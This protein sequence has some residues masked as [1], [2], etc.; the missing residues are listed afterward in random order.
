M[1]SHMHAISPSLLNWNGLLKWVCN[2]WIRQTLLCYNSVHQCEG[3]SLE[4]PWSCRALWV[5]TLKTMSTSACMC[6]NKGYNVVGNGTTESC[7]EGAL[8]LHGCTS[9]WLQV[10][11]S[12]ACASNF[13]IVTNIQINTSHLSF[14]CQQIFQLVLPLILYVQKKKKANYVLMDQQGKQCFLTF[15]V[16]VLSVLEK[17]GLLQ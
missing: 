14:N 3:E 17:W 9:G 5:Q 2:P 13:A 8:C 4:L 16:G 15:I 7:I 10:G 12:S 1:K 6:I 11:R